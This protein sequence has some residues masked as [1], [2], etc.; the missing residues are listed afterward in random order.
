MGKRYQVKVGREYGSEIHI[1]IGESSS[2][3]PSKRLQSVLIWALVVVAASTIIAATLY[4]F[5][6]GDYAVLKSLAEAASDLIRAGAR[7]V[8]PAKP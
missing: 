5:L 8:Q 7:L 2:E 4:G 6:T 1:T 3:R